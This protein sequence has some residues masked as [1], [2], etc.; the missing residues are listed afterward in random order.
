[1]N[2]IRYGD[3]NADGYNDLILVLE[4]SDGEMAPYILLNNGDRDNL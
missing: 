4:D 3:I 1:M 2:T